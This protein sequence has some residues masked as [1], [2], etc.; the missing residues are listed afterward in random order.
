MSKIILDM[1]SGNTS[2][3]KWEIAKEMIDNTF[4]FGVS[5]APSA[6]GSALYFLS[7]SGYIY[8]IELL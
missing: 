4:L 2:K 3:N 1:G 6:L 5:S 8:G 7:D